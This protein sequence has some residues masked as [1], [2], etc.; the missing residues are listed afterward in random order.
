VLQVLT[1]DAV[2]GT[3]SMVATLVERVDRR[4]LDVEVATL[5]APGPVAL[6]LRSAGVPVRSLGEKGLARAFIRLARQLRRERYDVVVAYGFKATTVVRVLV[7]LVCRETAFVSGVRGLHPAALIRDPTG[8]AGRLLLRLERL[9]S[10]L[11]DMYD[12]NSA[13]ALELLATS[14]IP[15]ERLHYI[16]NGLD[17]AHWPRNGNGAQPRVPAVVCVARFSSVKRHEDLLRATAM[18][19]QRGVQIRLDLVGDG[20]TRDDARSLAESLGLGGAVNFAG[21]CDMDQ[22]HEHLSS[23]SVFCL[24]SLHEGM[25]G[26]V[27]EA[28][29]SGLPVVGTDVNGISDLVEHGRT[30]LLVPPRHPERLADALAELVGDAERARTMGENG[31]AR[32]SARF[33]VERMVS[34]KEEL[35]LELA[36]RR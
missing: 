5:D 21:A 29:A 11:V 16:P 36:A 34:A 32:V 10:R 7:W 15:R 28:M 23:A 30:G 14:G 19:A 8:R 20:P 27:M 22:V 35:Y 13:G 25:A 2:G 24:P 12:A 31:R 9:S 3:E 1:C 18:L 17:M 33:G 26:S 6:R 4:R